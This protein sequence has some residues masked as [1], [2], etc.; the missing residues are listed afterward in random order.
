MLRGFTTFNLILIS[1]CGHS[2]KI[3]TNFLYGHMVKGK[4]TLKG[5]F[6]FSP[7]ITQ[8]GQ[9]VFD[10]ESWRSDDVKKF[11]SWK[12]EYFES[13]RLYLEYFGIIST[14]TG[15]IDVMIPRL[16]DRKIQLFETE[17]Q[18]GGAFG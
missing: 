4:D 15:D 16:I 12:Y 2:Q 10:R 13:D 7:Q 17:I 1:F 5:Y 18:G 3:F 6:R 8:E 9:T 14:I 11:Q